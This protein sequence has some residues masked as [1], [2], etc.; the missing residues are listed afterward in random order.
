MQENT[1]LN[2]SNQIE[3]F[4][5][6]FLFKLYSFIAIRQIKNMEKKCCIYDLE[7]CYFHQKYKF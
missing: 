7:I 1:Y 4:L 6:I 3:K 5:I 2:R